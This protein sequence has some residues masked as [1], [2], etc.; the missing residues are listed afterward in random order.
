MCGIITV[1]A[2]KEKGLVGKEII[3]QYQMQHGRGT[4]GFGLLEILEDQ[5]HHTERATEP[6]KAL[7]DAMFSKGRIGIF[8]HR[9]P[10]STPNELNQTHPFFISHDELAFDYAIVHNGVISNSESLFKTHTEELGYVYKTITQT[11]YS[12]GTLNKKF[13]DSEALSIEIARYLDGISDEIKTEGSAAFVGIRIDKKTNKAL[14]L[15]WGRNDRNPLEYLETENHVIIASTIYET[16]AIDIEEFTIEML[17]INKFIT[18]KKTSLNE[19]I[20]V[21]KLKFKKPTP[22]P[23]NNYSHF[24]FRDT[25]VSTMNLP[26]KSTITDDEED[27]EIEVAEYNGG[28]KTEREEAFE[29]MAER[30]IAEVEED[31]QSL[32]YELAYDDIDDSAITDIVTKLE[33]K[34]IEK[35]ESA[36]NKVRPLF[37]FKESQEADEKEET[38]ADIR[39]YSVNERASAS[40]KRF[41]EIYD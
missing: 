16:E 1:I 19:I 6:T 37:D 4:Q 9:M 27:I 13:N 8:H 32:F 11:Q 30:I 17:N 38:L 22:T 29:K 18:S 5:T 28:Y 41:E 12:Y 33:N 35:R 25:K 39:G 21:D 20:T 40:A 14:D 34:L 36:A 15:F 23:V 2:K 31:I 26:M 7:L 10:T 3:K 24:G